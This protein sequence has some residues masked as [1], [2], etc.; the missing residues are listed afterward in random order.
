LEDL[1]DWDSSTRQ[2]WIFVL[3]NQLPLQ[4]AGSSISPCFGPKFLISS[5]WSTPSL[6]RSSTS[7]KPYQLVSWQESLSICL[8]SW[9]VYATTN[10]LSYWFLPCYR[11]SPS[12]RCH[13]TARRN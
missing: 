13:F 4:S 10:W 3:L 7:P 1:L 5:T 12:D 6:D 2:N 8:L 11:D 9:Q